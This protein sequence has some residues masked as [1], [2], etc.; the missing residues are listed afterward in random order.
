M[1]AALLLIFGVLWQ[2]GAAAPTLAPESG[3]GELKIRVYTAQG[4]VIGARVSFAQAGGGAADRLTHTDEAGESL[5]TSLL[6]GTYRVQVVKPS[7]YVREENAAALGEILLTS[8]QRRAL[9]VEMKKGGVL[10]G[11]LRDG[12]GAR[13]GGLSVTALFSSSGTAEWREPPELESNVTAV[14]DDLGDFRL[15]G[16]RPGLYV[17]G[18]N[19]RRDLSGQKETPTFYYPGRGAAKRAQAIALAEGQEIHLPDLQIGWS[20]RSLS[21]IVGAVSRNGKAM[22]GARVFL[23]QP[24]GGLSDEATTGPAGEFAFAAL[25]PG[26]YHLR[27]LLGRR[28]TDKVEKEVILTGATPLQVNLEVSPAPAVLDGQLAD[29]GCR[30][31]NVYLVSVDAREFNDEAVTPATR[32]EG[33]SF[34]FQSMR[35]GS[36]Y[37][38]ALRRPEAKSPPDDSNLEDERARVARLMTVALKTARLKALDL[39]VLKSGHQSSPAAPFLLR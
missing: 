35:P 16:L 25:A 11:R 17:L 28:E 26:T 8:G 30:R 18:V 22:V 15:Y 19:T 14:S 6:P 7:L 1:A 32:C 2:T 24:G 21:A 9:S 20:D 34:H 5:F 27:V 37:L 36:F 12:A 23:S 3:T 13:A 33:A 38:V 29:G 4:P 31:F 10:I 39:L